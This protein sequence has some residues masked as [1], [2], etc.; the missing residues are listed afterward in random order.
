MLIDKNKHKK[1]QQQKQTLRKL[2]SHGLNS[3]NS[4]KI[5]SIKSVHK[6]NQNREWYAV[7]F[8]LPR[9]FFVGSKD[10]TEFDLSFS[11]STFFKKIWLAQ[12]GVCLITVTLTVAYMSVF[13]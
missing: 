5:L 8:Q 6:H 10:L 1:K 12:L 13:I 7:S 9:P 2:S 11:S 3:I 4:N